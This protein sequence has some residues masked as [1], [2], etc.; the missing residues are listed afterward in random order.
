MRTGPSATAGTLNR[1]IEREIASPIQRLAH[2]MALMGKEE[3]E[4]IRR[5]DAE[6]ESLSESARDRALAQ[7]RV[8]ADRIAREQALVETIKALHGIALDAA[9]ATSERE[10]ANAAR[11]S[12]LLHMTEKLLTLTKV[13]AF[14]AVC[15]LVVSIITALP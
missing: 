5:L 9:E 11:E 8:E 1:M 2:S 10:K 3:E 4:R 14:I 15:A 12:R 13:I 6:L 7:A